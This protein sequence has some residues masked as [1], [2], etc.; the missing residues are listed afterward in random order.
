M[1]Q[2]RA[3]LVTRRGGL[4]VGAWLGL[5]AALYY[6]A[7]P[8]ESVSRDDNVRFFPAGY[9]SVVGQ[10]LLERGFPLDPASSQ[11]LLVYERK[12]GKLTDADRACVDR[13]AADL[14]EFARRAD[15]A[16]IGLKKIDTYKTPVI[17]AR[18]VGNAPGGGQ[19]ALTIVALN[20]TYLA[21]STRLGVDKIL[22]F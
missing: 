6:A 1:F 16:T 15:S 21:K 18:L 20:G 3:K 7:P 9:T 11:V 5:A 10:D 12:G 22:G 4:V 13:D 19:A 2:P 8:W 14:Y 17:G